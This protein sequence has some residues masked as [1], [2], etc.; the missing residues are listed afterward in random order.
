MRSART[1]DVPDQG[2]HRLVGVIG[3]KIAEGRGRRGW[4]I[5]GLASRAGVASGLVSQLERGIGNPSLATLVAIASALE[6]PIGV[7]FE[8]TAQDD[9]LVVRRANRKHLVLNDRGMTYELLVPDLR[10]NLSMLY[11]ELPPGFSNEEVPF[12]HPGEEAELVLGG[13]LEAHIGSGTYRLD[14]GDSIR[15]SCVLPHWFRTFDQPVV[16]VSAMTPP[17]F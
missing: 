17:S 15:F 16:V 10:G 13:Q 2:D 8:G 11:I 3:P 5:E 4:S 7:F 12:S 6:I 14:A 9:Q 1:R